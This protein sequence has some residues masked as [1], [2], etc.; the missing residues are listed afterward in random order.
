MGEI[1]TLPAAGPS[2]GV[3]FRA[4]FVAQWRGGAGRRAFQ[5]GL[6]CGRD[7]E[8]PVTG[9]GLTQI[10]F[11]RGFALGRTLRQPL[12]TWLPRRPLFHRRR[13]PF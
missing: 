12:V 9:L 2:M 4:A 10:H 7:G 13:R 8:E 5:C 11:D 1:I 6:R 3:R